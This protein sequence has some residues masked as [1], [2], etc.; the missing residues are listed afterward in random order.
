MFLRFALPYALGIKTTGKNH[1]CSPLADAVA[2]SVI[3]VR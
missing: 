1:F 2:E 3:S